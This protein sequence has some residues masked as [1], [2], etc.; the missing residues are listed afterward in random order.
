MCIYIYTHLWHCHSKDHIMKHECCCINYHKVKSSCLLVK[1][2]A[3][4]G[5]L[6]QVTQIIRLRRNFWVVGS[7][8]LGVR[9]EDFYGQWHQ[10]NEWLPWWWLRWWWW[11]WPWCCQWWWWWWYPWG[12]WCWSQPLRDKCW[13]CH[14]HP[15]RLR[16]NQT[17]Y[18]V[19]FLF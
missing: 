6:L 4:S 5:S 8:R 11:W 13:W 19:C 9:R 15:G 16:K 2:P 12:C 14:R 18:H 1:S 10:R 17:S 7:L 3:H